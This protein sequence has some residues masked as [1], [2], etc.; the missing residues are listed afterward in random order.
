MNAWLQSLIS[1]HAV[2]ALRLTVAIVLG[3]LAVL[4]VARD[5]L[6]PFDHMLYDA[7]L[8]AYQRPPPDD[9]IIVAVDEESLAELGVWPLPRRIYAE[10]VD[11][12]HRAGARVVAIDV[13]FADAHGADTEG[14]RLLVARVAESGRTVLPV[15]FEHLRQDGQL[16]ELLPF[17]A[18]A[19]VVAGLGHVDVE[20]DKGGRSRRVYLNAGLGAPVWSAFALAALQMVD[21]VAAAAAGGWRSPVRQNRS[22]EAGGIDPFVWVRRNPLLVPFAGP[23]GHF[24]Q[25]GLAEVVGG[26][27]AP[28][29]FR[30][31]AV[32]VGATAIMTGDRLAIGGLTGGRM[33]SGAEFNANVFD[34]VRR[35]LLLRPVSPAMAM[36]LTIGLLLV[37]A[38][39]LVAGMRRGPALLFGGAVSVTTSAVL[40]AAAQLWFSPAAVMIALAICGLLW[41]AIDL[42]IDRRLIQTEHALARTALH[43]ISDAVVTL[44]AD[45]RIRHMNTVAQRLTGCAETDAIGQPVDAVVNLSEAVGRTRISIANLAAAANAKGMTMLAGPLLRSSAGEER[46]VQFSLAA[47]LD[48][49]GVTG[50]A[51]LVFTDV[52][53][54]HR[55]ANV[56]AEQAGRDQLTQLQNRKAFLQRLARALAVARREESLVALLMLRLDKFA[57]IN[58]QFGTAAA[59]LFLKGAVERLCS[60]VSDPEF[61]AR[62]DTDSFALMVDNLRALESITFLAHRVRKAFDSSFVVQGFKTWTSL[63]IGIAFFPRDARTP[64]GL[65]ARAAQA[66]R[67]ARQAGGN[68]VEYCA[69]HANVVDINRA[70]LVV[71]LKNA[72]EK[73]DVSLL[74]QPQIDFKS[75]R[76]VG[77]EALLRLNAPRLR[78]L[79][80]AEFVP[81]IEEAGLIAVTGEWVL[82]TACR[83]L[84]EWHQLGWSDLF[85]SINLTPRQ[86]LEPGL[87][88]RIRRA[89]DEAGLD[90]SFLWLEITELALLSDYDRAAKVICGVRDLGVRF[91]IDDFGTKCSSLL[92]LERLPVQ[93][94]KVDSALIQDGIDHPEHAAVIGAIAVMA[95][96]M[97]L[98]VIAEGVETQRH[99]DFVMERDFDRGQ[100]YFISKPVSPT[101]FVSYLSANVS[102]G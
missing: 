39:V 55:M 82:R 65:L 78:N 87:S 7:A 36:T 97:R 60:V 13:V 84:K 64:E 38:V 101:Q 31:A 66:A 46:K 24:R 83:Q 43:S 51:V 5:W 6:W 27:V 26:R 102:T 35:G 2:L 57:S 81:M 72:V 9:V 53:D 59:E 29:V 8:L 56:I 58:E 63:S 47:T 86:L 14:D 44:S 50:G 30:D 48:P 52:T 91:C 67:R 15:A 90:G 89:L 79:G 96:A 33:M 69:D 61:L 62:V 18:L 49:S 23:A 1:R 20:I 10:A 80:P 21:P 85:V 77:V 40:L 11:I 19:E 41:M 73:Q 76:T 28:D 4:A 74:Y 100:G 37:P 32:F 45:S 17:P 88:E 16:I 95:H 22:A 42:N 98:D 54:L 68:K 25:I 75:G 93:G 3:I 99:V 70:K 12:L 71:S 34:A 94:L 92:D